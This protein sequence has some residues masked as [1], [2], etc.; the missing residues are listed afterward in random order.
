MIIWTLRVFLIGLQVQIRDSNISQ[1]YSRVETSVEGCLDRSARRIARASY[2][3][4]RVVSLGRSATKGKK[5]DRSQAGGPGRK[6]GREPKRVETS[7]V[8][9]ID[10]RFIAIFFLF[11]FFPL[12][13]PFQKSDIF[14]TIKLA[15][16]LANDR[17]GRILNT[18]FGQKMK[19]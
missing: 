15:I 14:V 8:L 10:R 16:K 11:F 13:P 2:V 18:M 6:R 3:F 17:N 19:I 4:S 9:K 5:N 1:Y 12:P 7:F